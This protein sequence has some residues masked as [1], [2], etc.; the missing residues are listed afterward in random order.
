MLST[1]AKKENPLANMLQDLD[2]PPS[3]SVDDSKERA[4]LKEL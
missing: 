3:R 4:E 1:F 2:D